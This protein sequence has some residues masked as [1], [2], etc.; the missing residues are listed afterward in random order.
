MSNEFTGLLLISFCVEGFY[1]SKCVV[2]YL[3]LSFAFGV[4]THKWECASAD[5]D[6]IPGNLA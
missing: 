3:F 4:F 6:S 1:G 2:I 5:S